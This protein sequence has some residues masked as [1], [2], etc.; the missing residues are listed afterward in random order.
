M[1]QPWQPD[2]DY[3]R[4]KTANKDIWPTVPEPKIS[5]VLTAHNDAFRLPALLSAFDAQVMKAF[6]VI[7]VDDGSNDA[8]LDHARERHPYDIR[9]IWKPNRG[10]HLPHAINLGVRAARAGLVALSDCGC[11][12]GPMWL[13]DLVKL[14]CPGRL[15]CGGTPIVLEEAVYG[16]PPETLR[17]QAALADVLTHITDPDQRVRRKVESGSYRVP[18]SDRNTKNA[19]ATASLVVLTNLGFMVTDFNSVGGF[20]EA[21]DAYGLQDYEFGLRWLRWGGEV[22]FAPECRNYN[23][24][25]AERRPAHA[26]VAALFNQLAGGEYVRSDMIDPETQPVPV[27]A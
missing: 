5:V 26:K 6:E 16:V 19:V 7:L 13:A 12:P 10:F 15:V 25:K 14:I 20:D 2:Y 3:R 21:Y 8:A 27:P 22:L 11:V 9:Y 18:S 4:K 23:I 1:T 17:A 24:G